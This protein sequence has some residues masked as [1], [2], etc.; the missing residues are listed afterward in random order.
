[1][2][3]RAFALRVAAFLRRD[4]L[5][6]W[7]YKFSFLYDMGA[8]FS[9][10]IALFFTDR[11]LSDAPPR[12][13]TAY[14][15]DYFTFALVGIAFLDY[16]WVSMRSFAQQVR[17]AQFTGTLEAMLATPTHPFTVILCQAA[18]PYLWTTIRAALYLVL[19]ALV[20]GADLSRVDVSS[21]ALFLVLMVV[22]FA[23]IGLTS[24]AVTLYLK[25]ADPVT[26]LVGGISFLFGGIVYPVES[27]PAF[28]QD[29][30]WV[31]PMTHAVEGLRRAFL[32]GATPVDLWD[33]AAVLVAWAAFSFAMAALALRRVMKALSREGSFG[34]Y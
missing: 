16:M 9:S 23:G 12:T 34:A 5:F 29:V 19:G 26:A 31:L 18:W 6:R 22:T 20:F 10:L 33:H 25:Q 8:L 15:T 1:M 28:A 14:G 30:A 24:A 13:V 11:M 3:A 4:F 21:A 2:T 7:S 32:S 17:F 27:L